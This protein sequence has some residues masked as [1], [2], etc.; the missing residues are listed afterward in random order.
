[1]I[2][3]CRKLLRSRRKLWLVDIVNRLGRPDPDIP[4]CKEVSVSEHGKVSLEA[5][6]KEGRTPGGRDKPAP[7]RRYMT[8]VYFMILLFTCIWKKRV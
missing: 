3:H 4:I 8:A 5:Q 2:A 1:M 6:S 7:I